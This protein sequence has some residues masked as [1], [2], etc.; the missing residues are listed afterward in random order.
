[1]FCYN[2]CMEHP[3][4]EP[5][6]PEEWENEVYLTK[7][8]DRLVLI[9]NQSQQRFLKALAKVDQTD[10]FI[11][12]GTNLSVFLARRS[13]EAAAFINELGY[14]LDDVLILEDKGGRSRDYFLNPPNQNA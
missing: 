8:R 11:S 9:K 14:T 6:T 5:N 3:P 4:I 1:M 13:N 2:T 7:V 12:H 10:E